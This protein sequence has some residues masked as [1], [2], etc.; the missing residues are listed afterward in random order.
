MMETFGNLPQTTLNT[1]REKKEKSPL[2][3]SRRIPIEEKKNII[4][5]VNFDY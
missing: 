2:R 5:P 3:S 1:E 4:R